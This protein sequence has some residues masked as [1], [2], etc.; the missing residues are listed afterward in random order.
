MNHVTAHTRQAAGPAQASRRRH[1]LK[2]RAARRNMGRIVSACLAACCLFSVHLL[3]SAGSA[4]QFYTTDGVNVRS[5]PSSESSVYFAIPAGTAV[6]RTGQSGNWIAVNVDG[7]DG[8]I[9]KDYLS[10]NPD[11]AYEA[12]ADTGETAD[13]DHSFINSTE[14]NLRAEAN[15]HC[16]VLAVLDVNE[17]VAVLSTEGNWTRILRQ[18]GQ[19]GYV[20]SIYLGDNKPAAE[21]SEEADVQIS[22]EDCIDKFRSLAISY[23]E[24]RIGD[25]YSQ[26]LRDTDGYADCSSLVRDSFLSA[27]GILIGNTTTDQADTMSGYFYDVNKITDAAPGDL[28]YHL[29]GDHHAGIYLGSGQVLHASQ[30]AGTVKISSY[31]DESSYWEYGCNAAAYCFDAQ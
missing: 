24:G 7:V 18:N 9:Y 2:I 16:S 4:G 25:T 15:S 26:E 12:S 30:N 11:S 27:S 8:Y 14:V 13:A 28:L 20:Y 19:E 5:Q 23:A 21:E 10:E 1:A 29:S 22:R 31:S 3:S 6:A 17:T